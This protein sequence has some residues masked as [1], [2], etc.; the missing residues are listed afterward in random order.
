M[1]AIIYHNAR[2]SKSRKTLA[3]LEANSVAFET[4][5]YL[6]TPPSASQLK[7][8]L[9][10]LGMKAV[11]IV[12]FKDSAATELDLSAE[13]QRSESQWLELLAAN[14]KLIER[15]IVVVGDR[16]VIGRPPQNVLS[17][18]T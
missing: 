17:L 10:K 7:S 1:K 18:I 12:R 11:E 5:Y 8:I 3:L 16:A 9:K 4:V 14:P 15:P 6:E 2:C 13:D